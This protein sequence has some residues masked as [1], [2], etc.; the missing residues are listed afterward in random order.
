LP[1]KR[2]FA[3][4]GTPRGARLNKAFGEAEQQHT[5]LRVSQL[6][7]GHPFPTTE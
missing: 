6:S 1:P 7:Q 5:R 4:C 2:E 3:A